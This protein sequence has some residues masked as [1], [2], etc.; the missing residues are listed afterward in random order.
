MKKITTFLILTILVSIAATNV[1]S[2]LSVLQKNT[3]TSI[4]LITDY[5]DTV[6][7]PYF[8]DECFETKGI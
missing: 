7:I 8:D 4:N 1:T 6:Y 5:D 3:S 2:F